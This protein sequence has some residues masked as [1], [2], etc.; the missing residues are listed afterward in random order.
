[1]SKI[2]MDDRAL[3]RKGISGWV[4]AYY[5][6]D[7][8]SETFIGW[9]HGMEKDITLVWECFRHMYQLLCENNLP[10]PGECEVENHLMKGISDSLY[11]MFAFVRFCNPQNS[12]EKRAEHAIKL[13][14]Y[15]DE[16]KHQPN[17]GRWTNKHDAYQVNQDIIQDLTTERLIADD[18]ESLK[19][20]NQTKHSI[21]KNKT[22]WQ[23]LCENLNPELTK[24]NSRIL[25]KLI[26]F[27]TDTSLRNND[28]VRVQYAN[29][30]INDYGILK[31]LHTKELQAYYL[32]NANNTID[33]VYLWQG[34]EFMCE[35]NKIETYNEAQIERTEHDE[36][37]RIE[38][39][40]RQAKVRK[41]V[42][43]KTQ[44]VPKVGI[45]PNDSEQ[46]EA[47]D[48]EEI[49]PIALDAEPVDDFDWNSINEDDDYTTKKAKNDL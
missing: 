7:V 2:S 25:T 36:E 12:R 6:Y 34:D 40:K 49:T 33:K 39:A 8:Q 27:Q 42:K 45:M 32:P 41:Y 47:P 43:D 19:R 26:G 16:K 29:Y 11:S 24:P 22:R 46:F 4:N 10:W 1:M 20:H 21:Y 17:I 30:A 35:G 14:K 37:I 18:I 15:G 31:R 3:P 23:V 13:K 44:Q 5:A 9:S 28:F 38:Q 48:T